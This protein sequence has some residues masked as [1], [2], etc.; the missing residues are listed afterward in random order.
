M[1][2]IVTTTGKNVILHIVRTFSPR[3]TRNLNITDSLPSKLQNRVSWGRQN[4]QHKLSHA[5]KQKN[6]SHRLSVCKKKIKA[7]LANCVDSLNKLHIAHTRSPE[8]NIHNL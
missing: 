8:K 3:A 4:Y 6:V 7:I 1:N 5:D 2:P